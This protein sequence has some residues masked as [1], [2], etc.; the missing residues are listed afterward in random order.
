MK[1]FI[2]GSLAFDRS[3]IPDQLRDLEIWPKVDR[4]ALPRD[5]REIYD[6]YEK[7][8]ALFVDGVLPISAISKQTSVHKSHIYRLF[9][10]CIALHP[11]GR[12]FGLRALIP[13][14]RTKEYDRIE[15]VRA[16]HGAAGAFAKLLEDYPELHAFLVTKAKGLIRRTRGGKE[17]V[18]GTKKI[19]RDFVNKC[20]EL[21]IKHNEYPLNVDLLGIRSLGSHLRRVAS[22]NDNQ[23]SGKKW[24]KS[25]DHARRPITTPFEAVEFDG[26]KIDVRL[27]VVI[28]DPFGMEL[29]IELHRIWILLILDVGSRAAL[30]YLLALGREYNAD[31]VVETI[32]VAL[33]PHQKR[34]LKI[35]GLQY[36]S[37]GGFPSE[38]FPR[39]AYACWDSFKF[40][41]AKAH[42][43]DH[44]LEVL[45]EVVGCWP[46]AGPVYDPNKRPFVER[47][48]QLLAA[49]CAHRLPGTTGSK[50]EDVQRAIGDPGSD[51]SMLIRLEELEDLIDVMISNYNGEPHNGL[52]G[53]TPL[54][55]MAHHLQKHGDFIRTLPAVRRSNLC[56]LQQAFIVPVRGNVSK[57]ERPHINF[58]SVRYSSDVLSG[59]SGLIGRKLR[60]YANVKDLRQVKAFFDDGTEL[61]IL[62]AARAWA[63]TPHSLRMRKE[64]MRLR[65]L[66]K[67]RYGDGDDP[68]Q[69]YLNH[70]KKRAM[71]DK[72]AANSFVKGER[73]A[74][75][76]IESG[77]ANKPI[78]N[79][80]RS[81]DVTE[82]REP[83]IK[84]LAIKKTIVF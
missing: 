32:Q 59:N 9:Q 50:P 20:R 81:E 1:K 34:S 53:R 31:E 63:F 30:G 8:I 61:G 14:C 7:A 46:D 26:H 2:F 78:E 37:E 23:P 6:R 11:D 3:S 68:V 5:L 48:F 83:T 49:H 70:L 45:S 62:T 4:A 36:R 18:R 77:S 60:I 79:R 22:E 27:T 71:R 51:L 17:I 84:R 55:A 28:E 21:G 12:I 24:P 41:N 33:T 74:G 42:L 76:L 35:P 29:I 19:H 44:T 67:L 54:E 64:I 57:G 38:V 69:V 66:G 82:L 56:L 65:R 25:T 58:E 43:A 39:L 10:R 72:R 40:D 73:I 16:S 75:A 15:P 47:F 52:G 80:Q 13:F